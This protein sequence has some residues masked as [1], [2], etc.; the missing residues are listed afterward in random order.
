MD[1]EERLA[2]IVLKYREEL[3]KRIKDRELEMQ[4]DDT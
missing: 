1:K 4:G 2:R 3:Q